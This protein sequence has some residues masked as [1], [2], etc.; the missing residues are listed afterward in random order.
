[1]AITAPDTVPVFCTTTDAGSRTAYTPSELVSGY[2]GN[3][4]FPAFAQNINFQ[5]RQDTETL[6]QHALVIDE[7]IDESLGG[8]SI[9]RISG[10]QLQHKY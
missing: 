5:F 4:Q 10:L 2:V 1:M 7:I 8:N 3:I 6:N 9:G